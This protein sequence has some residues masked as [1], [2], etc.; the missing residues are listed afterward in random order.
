MSCVLSRQDSEYYNSLK[1]ILE[2]DPTELDLRF[3]ID[4]DNFGQVLRQITLN[5]L[6]S[7]IIVAVGCRSI[8]CLPLFY[9]DFHSQTYQVDL[10]PSGSDMVV[11]NENKKEYIE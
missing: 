6:K 11:T 8:V 4:E 5:Q 10:K 2:N 7:T 1:W 9:L 3:C